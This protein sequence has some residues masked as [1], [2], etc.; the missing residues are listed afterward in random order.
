MDE[1]DDAVKALEAA[2]EDD[3]NIAQ[4]QTAAD[5]AE[6]E[7]EGAELDEDDAEELE[8]LLDLK[9]E[10]GSE[11]KHGVVLIPESDFEDYCKDLCDDIGDIPKDLPDYIVID[12]EATANNLRVDYSEAEFQGET[13]LYRV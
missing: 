3:P 4:L 6:V 1:Y 5:A 11:W 7:K 12:W 2:K 9:E 8:E 10:V 13:Y